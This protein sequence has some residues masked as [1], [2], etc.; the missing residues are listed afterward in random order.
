MKKYHIWTIGCQMNV[1]DSTH[2]GAELEKLGY[3]P[4][5]DI[6]EAEVVVLNTCVVRQ[7]AE[8]KAAGKLGSLKPWRKQN[9][10]RTLALMGCMVGVK[11]SPALVNAFPWV[12]VFMA[13]SEAS[14]LVDYIRNQMIEGELAALEQQQL[15]RRYQFQDDAY[16]IAS[17]KHLALLG[18]APVAAHVP[19]VYG[20]SH[21]CTFCIIPFRRGIERSRP[22]VEIIQ[23]IRGLVAQ[24]VKEVTLLGQ[25]VDRYGYDHGD[26][27][28]LTG[29]LREVHE[30]AGLERIRFLT[31]HPNYMTDELLETV[32]ALPK[33]MPHIEAPIQAGD[34]EVL[35]RMKR[36]YTAKD[37]RQLV[38]RIRRIIPDVAIHTDIIV[39]FPGESDEQFQQTYDILEELRLDKAHLARYSPRPGTVSDRRMIDD[40]PDE[41][42]RRRHQLLEEQHER[43]SAEINRRWQDK[44]VQVLV[45]D[46]HKGKWRGRTP[47]NRLVFF[48]DERDLRGQLLDVRITW[49]G[50]W[51]MQGVPADRGQVDETIANRL[52]A[53][54]NLPTTVSLIAENSM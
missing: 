19:V 4:T 33:L 30:V 25:I 54:E 20:C 23:E 16:P 48:S 38:A 37:Y 41:E 42:K 17:V 34:N 6:D 18:D 39:G 13:P 45:E 8:D 3:E 49:T 15:Q 44:T 26:N 31:S 50:P 2:V 46:R 51:S 24:G 22:Q 28:G 35:T 52:S 1:A 7:S 29:L 43:I 47:Q 12:D 11:P 36:G 53:Q 5:A 14:P 9:P 32:A 40:V 27:H 10:D 21:A